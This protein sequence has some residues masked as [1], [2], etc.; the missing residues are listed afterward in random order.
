ME[1][2]SQKIQRRVND[3]YT[4]GILDLLS[5]GP[6][7]NAVMIEHLLGGLTKGEFLFKDAM[8]FTPA[9]T[10]LVAAGKVIPFSLAPG[11]AEVSFALPEDVDAELVYFMPMPDMDQGQDVTDT[12]LWRASLTSLGGTAAEL[13]PVPRGDSPRSVDD[14]MSRIMERDDLDGPEVDHHQDTGDGNE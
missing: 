13:I 12:R 7:S 5:Y 8:P 14:I 2:N 9:L 4:A 10:E 11:D 1:L 6:Q 3:A